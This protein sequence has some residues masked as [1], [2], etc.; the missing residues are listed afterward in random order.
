MFTRWAFRILKQIYRPGYAYHKAGIMLLDLVLGQRQ[1]SLF[2]AEGENGSRPHAL[3]QVLDEINGR[4]GR[5]TLQ[6]ASEGIA[7]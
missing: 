3:M 7:R 2:T 5:R 4:Y 1:H 6:F